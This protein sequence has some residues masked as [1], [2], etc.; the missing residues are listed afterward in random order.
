M[1]IRKLI[2]KFDL[3]QQERGKEPV[4]VQDLTEL[5]ETTLRTQERRFHSGNERIQL[6]LLHDR[7]F[8]REPAGCSRYSSNFYI[9]LHNTIRMEIS[10]A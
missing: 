2:D 10:S 1:G 5:N 6:S 8:Y 4:Y 9:L 3:D 7:Y